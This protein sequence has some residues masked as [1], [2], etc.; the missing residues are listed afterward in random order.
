MIQLWQRVRLRRPTAALYQSTEADATE[1]RCNRKRGRRRTACKN[2]RS[3]H[4][5]GQ[6][7]R[8]RQCRRTQGK[9]SI[10]NSDYWF[11]HRRWRGGDHHRVLQSHTL[12]RA[13]RA[14][15]TL[16]V[17]SERCVPS[18]PS[19]DPGRRGGGGACARKT[20]PP[21]K[22]GGKCS[23]PVIPSS[24]NAPPAATGATPGS[25]E[26][27]NSSAQIRKIIVED[28]VK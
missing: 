27:H 2:G 1:S 20:Q 9:K 13:R 4:C 12:W 22:A 19:L 18:L 5:T 25:R 8:L 14:A 24:E 28:A 15:T 11:W 10:N 6:R 21:W 26:C 17:L 16:T 23:E 7:A 3:T